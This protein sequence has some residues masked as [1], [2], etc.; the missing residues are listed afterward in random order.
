MGALMPTS[1]TLIL[2]LQLLSVAATDEYYQDNYQEFSAS[3]ERG[4]FPNIFNL[5][6]N[7]LIWADATCGQHQREIF[8]KLVEHVFNRQP[9]CDVCDMNDVN[10]RHPIEFA[11][12]GTPKW[13]QSPSLANGLEYERE[14]QVAYIIVKSAIAPRPGTW[15]LEKSMDGITYQSWQY[16]ATSDAECMRHFGVPAT[17]GVPRFTRDDE[18]I[19][20]SYYSKL[21]PLE[22]GEIHTSLVNGR[23]TAEASS[24]L[25]QQF[26]C[27]RYVR[28]RLLS[29]R[30]LN[31]DLMIINHQGSSNRLDK[32]VTRRY[33]YAIKD[34]S[35]GGQCICYGH[36][37]SCPPDP[38]TGQFRC[39]CRHNTCGES[40]SMCCP[41][42][43]QLPWK[44]GTQLNPNICQAC[45]CFNHA[46]RCEYDA[47]VERLGLSVT[48]EG[49]FEGGGRC[50]DCKHNTDGINCE[51]CKWTFYRPSGITHYREDAC[52]PCDCDPLGSEHENCVRDDT[53]AVNGQ[54]PGD[55][56]CK[57]GFGGRR[58]DRCAAGYRNHPKCEPCPC[59]QA[60][61]LNFDTCE[62]EKCVC[63]ANVEGLYCDRCKHPGDCICK[64]GFGGRRCDRCAAGYRNHPKCEPCPCNQA[65]SLNFDTC[66]EEK[67]VC[68]ANVEGLYCDRCKPGTINLNVNNPQGCQPCFCFGLG[69]KCFEKQWVTGQIR[70]NLGWRL[71]DLSGQSSVEP[72]IENAELLIYNANDHKNDRLYYWKASEKFLGNLLNSYG[73]MLHYYVYFVPS[74]NGASVPIADL[75]LEDIRYVVLYAV[76]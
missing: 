73:G 30:T 1:S 53:S 38:I 36:A 22:N 62:E 27:A 21:D 67:C 33:F 14:Y 57:P 46:D 39:E 11:I 3:E 59:N 56:I 31:A 69:L 16:Y 44:Q 7:A 12:D 72:K 43:N 47:E 9:Q 75:I 42:F 4:L 41:L 48:P 71:T 60:G 76:T 35:I 63:K 65:G 8:C 10:K 55:C 52:R 45:Q 50:V 64:P 28:L 23:P 5:A 32:S 37:E 26:T 66:E 74:N 15:V 49:I 20:T 6:T 40:C 68:K 18:V 34:I 51:R 24:E 58:C 25:L 54:H 70:G 17:V 29:P 13:W 61:S 19:C 2:V